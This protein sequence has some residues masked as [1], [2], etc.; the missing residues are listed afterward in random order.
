MPYKM[1]MKFMLVNIILF[2]QLDITNYLYNYYKLL[3][4]LNYIIKIYD[5]YYNF[6]N[7]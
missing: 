1:I 5:I 2:N 6:L 3:R 7:M 4:N